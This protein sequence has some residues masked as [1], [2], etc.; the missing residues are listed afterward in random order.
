MQKLTKEQA[1]WVYEKI[2]ANLRTGEFSDVVYANDI[3]EA[4]NQCTEVEWLGEA[5]E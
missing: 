2:T 4:I 5:N 1:D 3:Q